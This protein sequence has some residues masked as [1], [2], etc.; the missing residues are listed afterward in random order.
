M[1]RMEKQA[2]SNYEVVTD[3]EVRNAA[4]DVNA[5]ETAWLWFA[6]RAASDAARRYCFERALLANPSSQLAQQG[7]E[8]LRQK[9]AA[10][11]PTTVNLRQRLQTGVHAVARFSNSLRQRNRSFIVE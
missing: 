11:Q 10:Q 6:E 8:Y 7:M 4:Y 3:T 1:N 9:Q 2:G 5:V